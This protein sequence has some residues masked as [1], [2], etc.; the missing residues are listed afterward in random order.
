MDHRHLTV[1][2]VLT[3]VVVVVG[4]WLL[5]A[6]RGGLISVASLLTAK[7][8]HKF[9]EAARVGV[10]ERSKSRPSFGL[11]LSRQGWRF[12]LSAFDDGNGALHQRRCGA[13]LSPMLP[14]SLLG[15]PG[16]PA[17]SVAAIALPKG[18]AAPFSAA[19]HPASAPAS[20]R[21]RAA[22]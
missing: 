14:C 5:A 19:V 12:V 4:L 18:A 3:V 21:R 15:R 13:H 17:V 6:L 16:I 20:H 22:G 8:Q 2:T 10:S 11:P 7:P 1:L 9:D